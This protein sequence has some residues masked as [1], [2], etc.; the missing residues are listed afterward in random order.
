MERQEAR[1]EQFIGSCRQLA[2]RRDGVLEAG[3]SGYQ[4]AQ[5]VTLRPDMRWEVEYGNTGGPGSTCMLSKHAGALTTNVP[6]E[7]LGSCH[8]DGT[9]H[10]LTEVSYQ[11]ALEGLR[12]H[13][14]V[15]LHQRTRHI[16]HAQMI[17]HFWRQRAR[18]MQRY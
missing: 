8:A 18:P 10:I 1:W 2:V 5:Q 12:T 14:A 6:R 13:L 4:V 3:G 11:P 9:G 15:P 17:P 16:L 7:P